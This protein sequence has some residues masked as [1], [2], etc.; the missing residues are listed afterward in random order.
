[1]GSAREQKGVAPGRG[2]MPHSQTLDRG[3][4][5][6]ELL[7]AA[8]R[9]ASIAALAAG[10][11]VH[12]SI[13]YRILRTLEDRRLVNRRPDGAYEL[14]VGLQI[15]A[16]NVSRSLREAA[17]PELAALARDLSMTAFLVVADREECVTLFS[18]EPRHT[19]IAVVARPGS[20]HRLDQGAPGLALLAGGP[21]SPGER[22]EVA[23]ARMAGYATSHDEVIPGLRSVAVPL[24]ES[25]G[26]V[27]A[28]VAVVYVDS[29]FSLSSLGERL[30]SAVRSIAA[31]L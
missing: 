23:V 5:V 27:R 6:L 10:L 14:G 19:A 16:R 3:I 21:P 12:R 8:E 22:P 13:V 17:M 9:P 24:P 31:E 26:G 1:M 30:T 7:A 25:D 20:R 11:G 4:Q 28:A 29:Q 18:V 15:L 2:E